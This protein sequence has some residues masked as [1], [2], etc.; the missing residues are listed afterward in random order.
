MDQ[1]IHCIIN[2]K[3]RDMIVLCNAVINTV[4]TPDNDSSVIAINKKKS[5]MK[6]AKDVVAFVMVDRRLFKKK[7]LAPDVRHL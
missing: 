4:T 2:D 5:E 7:T 6:V 3:D 1:I